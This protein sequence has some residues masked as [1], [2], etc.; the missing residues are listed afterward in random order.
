MKD[1]SDNNSHMQ[2]STRRALDPRKKPVQ[3]RSAMTVE[4]ISEVTIQV[5][6]RYGVEKLTTSRVANLAGVSVGTL[7]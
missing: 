2:S 4:A 7:Y 5:L 3:A 6:L 1:S